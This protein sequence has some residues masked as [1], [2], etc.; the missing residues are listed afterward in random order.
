MMM[1]VKVTE[2]AASE[3]HLNQVQKYIDEQL[4]KGRVRRCPD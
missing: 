4:E 1:A 3:Q 2:A